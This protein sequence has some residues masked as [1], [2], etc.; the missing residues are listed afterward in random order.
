MLLIRTTCRSAKGGE[1]SLETHSFLRALRA[2]TLRLAAHIRKHW[3]VKS[4]HHM[5][6]LLFGGLR[7][8]IAHHFGVDALPFLRHAE[9]PTCLYLKPGQFRLCHVNGDRNE[10]PLR[11]ALIS[12]SLSRT[13]RGK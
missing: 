12:N 10:L 3:E 13:P 4:L 11:D 1:N 8:S 2:D 6:E 7:A 5:K 9:I